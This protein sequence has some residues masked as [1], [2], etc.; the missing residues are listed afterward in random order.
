[1]SRNHFRR[2]FTLVELLVVITIIGILI[3]LL[4][5]AIMSAKENARGAQ[6]NNNLHEIGVAMLH[7]VTDHQTF[8]T[9]GWGWGWV[10][11]ADQ[12]YGLGQPGGW[13]YNILPYMDMQPF[14]DLGIGLSYPSTNGVAAVNLTSPAKMA[15]NTTR[16][17]KPLAVFNCPTRRRLAAYPYTTVYAANSNVA[18]DQAVPVMVG[19]TDYAANGG[20]VYSGPGAMGIWDNG[21]CYNSDCGPPVGSVPPVSSTNPSQVTLS[22]LS[23]TAQGSGF[24]GIIAALVM[25]S[26]GDITDGQSNTYLVGEKYLDPDEYT[27]GV[28]LGDNETMTMGDNED[29]TR[30]T[31]ASQLPVPFTPDRR[32]YIDRFNFG[33]AHLYGFNVCMCDGAVRPISYS[34]NPQ[35]HDYLGNRSDNQNVAPPPFP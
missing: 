8:P 33:S 22:T 9:G 4:M 15:A 6:C 21:D 2:G 25:V 24:N 34:I 27:S 10:G 17:T 26:P 18:N 29:I 20:D 31:T 30:Y 28:D 11:D 16:A 23:M 32:G 1:M 35:I 13:I 7:H 12:G 3:S 14:H 5:P 19:K